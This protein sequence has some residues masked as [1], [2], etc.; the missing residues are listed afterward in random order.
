MSDA[1]KACAAL[2]P[3]IYTPAIAACGRASHW[4]KATQLMETMQR[5]SVKADIITCNSLM[6]ALEKS[7]QWEL[8][9]DLMVEMKSQ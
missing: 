9:F 7:H 2:D 6:G 5:Q 1:S 8:V 4:E 3:V